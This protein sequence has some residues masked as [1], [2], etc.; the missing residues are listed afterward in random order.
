METKIYLVEELK[1]LFLQELINRTGGKVSKVSDHSVLN[2]IAFGS[3]KVFQKS[4]KDIALL[5]A[6]LFPEYAYGEY[7][8][9]IAQRYGIL[10]RQKELKSSV[11]VKLVATP[12]SLYTK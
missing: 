10:D 2:G 4:M 12:N 3:A 9:K 7:L 11:F 6:E 1:N 5:E 8:D